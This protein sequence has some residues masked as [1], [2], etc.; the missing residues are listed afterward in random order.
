MFYDNVYT[1]MFCP[2]ENSSPLDGDIMFTH[3]LITFSLVNYSQYMKSDSC[4]AHHLCTLSAP[5][6]SHM[7]KIF[8]KSA[9]KQEI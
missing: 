4:M 2:M 9:T 7:K 6:S 8:I 5:L 1:D 3:D